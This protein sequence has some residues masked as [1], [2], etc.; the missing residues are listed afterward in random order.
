MPKWVESISLTTF[1]DTKGCGPLDDIKLSFSA[2]SSFKCR[3]D[4]WIF[5]TFETSDSTMN[6]LYYWEIEFNGLSTS[7]HKIIRFLHKKGSTKV[8]LRQHGSSFF[9]RK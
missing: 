3:L 5:S 7:A 9:K 4:V 2:F 1:K 8:Y 6:L